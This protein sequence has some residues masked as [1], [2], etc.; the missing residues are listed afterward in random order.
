MAYKIIFRTQR[1][2][3]TVEVE[4]LYRT[5][6]LTPE[7]KYPGV[8]EHCGKTGIRYLAHV[9][10]DV[11]DTLLRSTK[12]D[13]ANPLRR[14]DEE[15]AALGIALLEGKTKK[16]MD[17]GCVCVAKYLIDCGVDAGL[18]ERLQYEVNRVTGYLQKL[19]ALEAASAPERV[20]ESLARH[21][22]VRKLNE[23]HKVLTQV[24]YGTRRSDEEYRQFYLVRDAAYK[25]F[26]EANTRWER[27]NFGY[28][29]RWGAEPT[30]ETLLAFFAKRKAEAER[31]LNQYTRGATFR[32]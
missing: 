19:A 7:G 31:K 27:E 20:A 17:V 30:S 3:T 21:A 13:A 10:Q 11:A 9:Q 24:G 25:N 1:G 29:N 32:A 6:G 22:I 12:E 4:D 23:R 2:N 16:Q 14:T 28:D 15:V 8:C 26:H 18:A 5:V